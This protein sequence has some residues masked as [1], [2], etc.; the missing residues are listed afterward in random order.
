MEYPVLVQN[1]ID[2]DDAKNLMAYYDDLQAAGIMKKKS[3][4]GYQDG[5]QM[6]WNPKLDGPLEPLRKYINLI[7][8]NNITGTKLYAHDI[9]IQ[10]YDV[11]PGMGIHSDSQGACV[12]DCKISALLYFNDDYQGGEI[13]FPNIKK[14]VKPDAL[15]LLTF[16]QQSDDWDHAVEEIVSGSRYV[17]I[18]CFTDNI[19][20]ANWKYLDYN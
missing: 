16:P 8:N 17:V 5:R 4:T 7:S 20:K 13:T 11:G 12:P 15:S 2:P 19:E 18:T 14:R 10:K 3:H 1:F 9:S 6:V